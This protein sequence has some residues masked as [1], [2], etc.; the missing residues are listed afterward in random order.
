[1]PSKGSCKNCKYSCSAF[2]EWREKLKCRRYPPYI[3]VKM[4]E[5][6]NPIT[7]KHND[8]SDCVKYDGWCGEWKG[9]GLG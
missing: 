9:R 3:S 1:M 8:T 2:P 7:D 6:L 5:R 4:D